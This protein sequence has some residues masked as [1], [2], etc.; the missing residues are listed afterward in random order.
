MMER[1]LSNGGGG[2]RVEKHECGDRVDRAM[3]IVFGFGRK[4]P[5]ENV[6]G[7]GVLA[8]AGIRRWLPEIERE[9]EDDVCEY[10]EEIRHSYEQRLEM[11]WSRPVNQVHVLDFEGLTPEMRQD[12]AVRLRVVYSREG[13]QVFVSQ[14]WRRLFGIRAPLVREFILGF[15]SSCRMSD[16]EM[17]LDVTDMLCFQLGGVRRSM[18]WR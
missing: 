18:T 1:R 9:E 7:G 13:Q 11:I 15:L 12:L 10:T 4:S 2:R 8:V 17:G 16:T 5:P 3:R 6:S 14:A